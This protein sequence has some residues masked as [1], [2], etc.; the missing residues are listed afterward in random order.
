MTTTAK[1]SLSAARRV[2]RTVR[3][4]ERTP[5]DLLGAKATR[6][7][8]LIP[9]TLFAVRVYI[10]GGTAGTASTTC[11]WTYTVKRDSGH[12]FGTSMTPQRRRF[13]NTPYTTTPDGAW[14]AGFFDKTGTFV[15]WDANELPATEACP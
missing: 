14:G 9:Q 7:Q 3:T 6:D 10:D 2:M 15:L 13:P 11:S 8:G 1:F 4:I 5:R 12:V